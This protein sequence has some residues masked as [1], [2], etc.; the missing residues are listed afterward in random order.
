MKTRHHYSVNARRK[1]IYRIYWAG[2][3][4]LFDKYKTIT[5]IA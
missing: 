5:Q 2:I 1:R 4:Q 3:W